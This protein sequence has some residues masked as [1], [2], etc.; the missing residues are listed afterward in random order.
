MGIRVTAWSEEIPATEDSLRLRMQAE[1]LRPYVWSNEPFDEYAAH[2]HGYDKVIYVVS[3]SITFG[4]PQEGRSVHLRTG[5]RLE[6]PAGTIHE[7][8]VGDAG[9][10]CLEAHR[11]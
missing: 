3:G 4:L 9:V 5:D 10:V 8:R 6:L 2:L 11:E 1:G 7:A